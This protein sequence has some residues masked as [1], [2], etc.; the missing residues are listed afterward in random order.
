MTVLVSSS[1]FNPRVTSYAG[2]LTELTRLIDGED[3]SVSDI[4]TETLRQIVNMGER[5]IYREVR[6][7]HNEKSFEGVVV[8]SNLAALPEDFESSSIV[9]FG[10]PP[11]RPI[12][13]EAL[14]MYLQDNPSGQASYFC[15]AGANFMFGP[16]VS[17][18]TELQG[19]YFCRLAD[20]S[21]TTLASNQL[22][23]NEYDLFV[24]GALSQAMGLFGAKADAMVAVWEAKYI[25]IRNALNRSK[26]RAAYSAGRI[27]RSPS[28]NVM[29]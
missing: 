17:D 5:R 24:Y 19:R 10:G 29:R 12:S 26:Q 13:E 25:E 6:S 8:A 16:A 2:F 18:G 23:R 27:Q 11:L 21:E 7:R 20:L 22:F 4:A 15:E 3:T 28:T 9:H 1:S 14:R